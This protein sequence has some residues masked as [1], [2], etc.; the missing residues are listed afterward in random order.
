MPPADRPVVQHDFE[1]PEPT[2]TKNG[3]RFPHT[4]FAGAANA[5]KS[6]RPFRHGKVPRVG[7]RGSPDS[8]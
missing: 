5:A 6:D 3:A 1:G 2:G 4:A 8:P 7:L